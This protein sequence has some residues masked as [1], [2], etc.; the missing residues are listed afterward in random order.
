M[1]ENKSKVIEQEQVNDSVT[2]PEI[3]ESGSENI[4]NEQTDDNRDS[5]LNEL[6]EKL[7]ELQDRYLRLSAEFD[8]YRKRTL[9]ERYELIKTAGEDILK[10][11]LPVL[12][13]FDRA[14][15]VMNTSDS[16]DAFLEGTNLIYNKFKSILESKG[17]TEINPVGAEFDPDIHEAIAKIKGTDKQSGKIIDVTQKGYSLNEKIIRHPKVVIGE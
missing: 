11:M 9:K 8:N 15:T 13:D 2:E 16:I 4:E 10:D 14:M 1:E 5:Q 12:D 7:A 17:L 3:V 6:T